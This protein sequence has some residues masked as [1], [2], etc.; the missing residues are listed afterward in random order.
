MPLKLLHTRIH[1]HI[2]LSGALGWADG[3]NID[4]IGLIGIEKASEF[5]CGCQRVKRIDGHGGA[6]SLPFEHKY[7]QNFFLAHKHFKAKQDKS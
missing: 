4:R 6:L 2:Q 1:T 7:T 5:L 3:V